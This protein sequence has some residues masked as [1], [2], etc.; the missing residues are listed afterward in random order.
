MTTPQ[1]PDPQQPPDPSGYQPPDLGAYPPPGQQGGYPPP[2]PHADPPSGYP[3]PAQ[4]GAYPPPDP[5]AY[6]PPGQQG[7]YPPPGTPGGPVMPGA[8][9]EQ[10]KKSNTPRIVMAVVIV[11]V[12]VLG[13]VLYFVNRGSDPDYAEV[14]DCIQYG[15]DTDV[16]VVDCTSSGAEYKVVKRVDGTSDQDA[17]T[18]VPDSDV[19]LFTQSGND[20]Q[21]T[22]CVSLVLAEGDCMSTNG[23]KLACTDADAAIKVIK[24]LT[25]TTDDSGCPA[26]TADSIV[27]QGDDQVLCLAS[28]S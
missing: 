18:S 21:Y 19:S 10:P 22:L 8:P 7:G 9:G 27:H 20:K 24:V 13:I 26:D 6:P 2:D 15:S 5:H 28:N 14:G 23:D 1:Y 3:P 11:A 4:P 12:V 17:C 25:G 16:N